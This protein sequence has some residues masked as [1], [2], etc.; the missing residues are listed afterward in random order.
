MKAQPALLL[1]L[2]AWALVLLFSV[3][4]TAQG[5][6]PKPSPTPTPEPKTETQDQVRVFTEEV[7]LPV[8]ATDAQGHFD[9]ALEIDDVLVLE[10]G[11][12]QTIRSV[13]HIP[14]NVLLVLDTGGDGNGL[15]GLSKKT[16]ITRAVAL[17]LIARLR[18]GDRVA[19]LQSS[20]RVEVLQAWTDDVDKVVRVLNTKLFAG[21]RSRIFETMTK[22]AQLLSEQPEGSRHVVLVTDGV[23]TPGGKVNLDQALKQV[24]AARATVHVLSYTS[25][26]RQKTDKSDVKLVTKTNP[27]AHDPVI[28]NDPTLPP[29]VN[30]GG[31]TFGVGITFDPAMRRVRKAYEAETRK[32]EKWLTVL[33]EETGGRIFLP[34]STDEMITQSEEVAREIGAEYVV[35]YRPRRP[36]AAAEPG[37]Y[38]KIEVASRRVGLYLRSRRGYIVPNQQ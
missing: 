5:Y 38:R 29:G 26:V 27:I 34:T 22:A 1:P 20:D 2:S 30:R 13:R 16:S 33:A 19:V 8:T 12:A 21:K 10:D 6:K 36:L 35:T 32:S 14:T 15:G 9:P 17:R 18:E 28:A 7:R 31:P 23:E 37:E 4:G 25:F 24:L 3:Q 11:V